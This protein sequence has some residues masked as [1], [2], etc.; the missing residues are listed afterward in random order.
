MV[1]EVDAVC[2]VVHVYIAIVVV[3]VQCAYTSFHA[4]NARTL[5]HTHTHPHPRT[6][7]ISIY[8]AHPM[9]CLTG[10]KYYQ[11]IGEKL[12]QA[13]QRLKDNPGAQDP[14]VHVPAK[15]PASTS[16]NSST[17]ITV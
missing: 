9:H 10:F 1:Y 6:F 4:H 14:P 11:V 16:M 3:L 5:T 2:V 13:K 15:Q 17:I 12:D 7:A 8:L